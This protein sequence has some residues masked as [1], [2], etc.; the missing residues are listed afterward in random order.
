MKT[1]VLSYS[2]TG[3]NKSLAQSIVQKISAD[4]IEVH[5]SKPKSYLSI[6]IDVLFNRTPKTKIAP[7]DPNQYDFILFISPV[8]MGQ[9]ASPLRFCFNTHKNR[10]KRYAF[11]SLSGGADGE[12]PKLKNDL[13]T[14]LGKEPELII[15]KFIKDLLPSD[16]E[17]TPQNIEAY[18]ASKDVIEKLSD[19]IF[20]DLQKVVH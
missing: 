16:I 14:R 4:H 3:N 18:T 1:L 6:G 8:W 19:S 2:R 20:N 10:I 7:F 5:E 17:P 15:N 13:T 9:V 12:N 11:V